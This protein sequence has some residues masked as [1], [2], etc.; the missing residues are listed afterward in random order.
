MSKL[1]QG[2]VW[3]IAL[4]YLDDII[5]FTPTFDDHIV[6]LRK[7]FDRLHQANLSLKPSKCEFG[8]DKIQFLGHIVSASGI[9]PV[10][11][12]IKIIKNAQPPTTVNHFTTELPYKYILKHW[13]PKAYIKNR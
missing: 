10:E 1:L 12:K 5:C 8:K 6:A 13:V 2:L 11:D 3:D 4:V 7:I 9:E